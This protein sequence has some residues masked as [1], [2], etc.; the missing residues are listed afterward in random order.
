MLVAENKKT[1]EKPPR[2]ENNASWLQRS[3][4][5]REKA[6]QEAFAD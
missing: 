1:A 2:D 6:D 3:V 4:A 5:K